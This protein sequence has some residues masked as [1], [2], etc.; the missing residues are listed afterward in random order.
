MPLP[1]WISEAPFM[2]SKVLIAYRGEIACMLLI[3]LSHESLTATAQWEAHTAAID[4]AAQVID[5][6]LGTMLGEE[7]RV[8]SAD[9]ARRPCD[10]RDFAFT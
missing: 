6:N 3:V 4:R 8:L 1:A 10:D 5:H 7:Q 2:F 9:S